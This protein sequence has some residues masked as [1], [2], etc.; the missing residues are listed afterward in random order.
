[1]KKIFISHS[2]LDS[3]IVG[4][5]IDLIESIGINDN[6]IFCS[7]FEGYG[8]E[9]GENFLERLKTELNEEIIAFFILTQNF[10]KSPISLC[11][12]GAVWIKSNKHIP[13]LIPPF[14]FKDIKGV[15]PVSQGMKIN[16]KSKLNTLKETLE[17]DFSLPSLR[18]SIWEKKRD[19]FL[20]DINSYIEGQLLNFN[21]AT[22]ASELVAAGSPK[23]ENELFISEN[24][25]DKLT[26]IDSVLSKEFQNYLIEIPSGEFVMGDENR[27]QLKVTISKPFLLAK[28][29]VKQ[30]LYQYIIK[31]NPSHFIGN[32]LPVENISWFDAIKFCNELSKK[33]GLYEIYSFDKNNSLIINESFS[34][35]R[36]PY[37]FEWEY[38]LN[39]NKK[40]MEN[41]LEKFAWFHDNSEG[42][43]HEVATRD[44][45]YF[46]IFDLLGNVWEWCNDSF[47]EKI[48]FSKDNSPLFL[49]NTS[50]TR[51][52]RGGS[53]AEFKS[54]FVSGF[55]KKTIQE[56]KTKFWGF[57]IIFQNK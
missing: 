19:K 23:T 43:T 56:N 6:Q 46:G 38:A 45:N 37:E 47:S 53:F 17:N 57:R 34:G 28:Y 55:R 32:D 12:M 2:S 36:L 29:P 49:D 26:A 51:V 24:V 31:N 44:P 9:L 50:S 35:F 3:P 54:Q 4:D 48:Q 13:I 8:I 33:V 11:E 21:K 41:N 7:S 5:L 27:G 18:T 16:D 20:N 52:L 10:Y 25:I 30:S 39:F 22:T 1:M 42:H 14:E 40:Q 15:F